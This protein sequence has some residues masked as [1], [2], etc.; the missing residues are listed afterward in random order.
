MGVGGAT[1]Y[2][3]C[4]KHEFGSL[5]WDHVL[6]CWGKGSLGNGGGFW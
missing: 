4:E 6:V 5:A 1:Y 2:D 3:V